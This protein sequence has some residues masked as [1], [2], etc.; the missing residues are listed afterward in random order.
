[1]IKKIIIILIF[2]GFLNSCGYQQIYSARDLNFSISEKNEKNSSL[3]LQFIRALN[4]FS[5][6]DGN[7]KFQV[8]IDSNKKKSVITKNSKGDP[9]KFEIIISLDVNVTNNYGA[10]NSIILKRKIDYDNQNDKFKLSQYENELE[11]LL[12]NKLVEDALAYFSNIQ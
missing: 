7:K 6:E 1:M 12:I 8:Q 9:D 10:E 4:A 5:N 3:N 11:K 2:C